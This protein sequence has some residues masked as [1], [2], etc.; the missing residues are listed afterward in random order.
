MVQSDNERLRMRERKEYGISRERGKKGRKEEW[1][2]MGQKA[3]TRRLV[4]RS[5]GDSSMTSVR[6]KAEVLVKRSLQPTSS[7]APTQRERKKGER[8][9]APT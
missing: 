5:V 8:G 9:D 3:K 2:R 4:T 6:N 7:S 1:E